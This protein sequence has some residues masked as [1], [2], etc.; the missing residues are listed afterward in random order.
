[1]EFGADARIRACDAH[2]H[3]GIAQRN[4][5]PVLEPAEI[6]QGVVDDGQLAVRFDPLGQEA[7]GR[8]NDA[9]QEETAR[10]RSPGKSESRADGSFRGSPG[11]MPAPDGQDPNR[12]REGL[13][14]GDSP[15]TCVSALRP[16]SGH[17]RDRCHAPRGPYCSGCAHAARDMQPVRGQSGEVSANGAQRRERPARCAGRGEE[18]RLA[19]HCRACRR[20]AGALHRPGSACRSDQLQLEGLEHGA[21]AVAHAELGQGERRRL[22]R[23]CRAAART[24]GAL[25]R[26]G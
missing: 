12:I 11:P 5:V 4:R 10:Q 8:Q 6:V 26:A 3:L 16:R 9:D 21:G 23:H 1:M 2:L 15:G 20:T 17:P 24:P 14:R 18:T 7:T 22:V 25:R 19:R 13:A